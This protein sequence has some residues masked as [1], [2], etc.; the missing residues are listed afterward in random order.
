MGKYIFCLNVYNEEQLLPDCIDSI[1]RHAPDAM[2]VAVDGIYQS[3]AEE[4][5]RLA[6]IAWAKGLVQLGDEYERLVSP[7][8]SMDKT[9]EILQKY[10]VDRIITTG[11]PW[12]NEWAK[13]SEYLKYGE[14]GDWFF[15]LDADERLEG[16]LPS[17]QAL[18][19]MGSPHYYV[20]LKRD[21]GDGV[22]GIF[23]IHKW[24]R[25]MMYDKTH[26]ALFVDGQLVNRRE[27]EKTVLPDLV[28]QHRWL[29]RAEITPIRHQIK[30][31]FYRRLMERDEAEF[32]RV[33]SGF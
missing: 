17:V 19:D 13:R 1:R 24:A 20:N 22:Y 5:H 8:P 14:P 30:G 15:I 2:I 10:K 23:R 12:V 33:N 31:E 9:L 7:G 6:G 16:T 28:I 26:Y 11:K 25:N 4:A 29:H 21:D 27:Y 18:E 3:F 32:R